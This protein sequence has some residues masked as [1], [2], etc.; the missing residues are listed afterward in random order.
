MFR[1]CPMIWQLLKLTKDDSHYSLAHLTWITI[2]KNPNMALHITELKQ[3]L[4]KGTNSR[5]GAGHIQEEARPSEI[6][7]ID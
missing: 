6:I 7:V 5:E 3:E 4:M 2:E 1:V